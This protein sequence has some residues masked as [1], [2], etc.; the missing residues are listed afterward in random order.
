MTELWTYSVDVESTGVDLIGFDVEATDGHIG[1][2]DENSV[3][4]GDAFIVVD[5]GFWIF[6][7]KRMIPARSVKQINVADRKV[8][9]SLTKD[10][11]KEGP[12]YDAVR[13]AEHDYRDSITGHYGPMY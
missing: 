8:F 4:A 3:T 6:G 11:V 10:Q 12:D 9:L 1:K 5:T 7:K 13:R 2:I